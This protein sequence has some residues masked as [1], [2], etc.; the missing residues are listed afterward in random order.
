[1]L[2]KF[3][4][5][6]TQINSYSDDVRYPT[7]SQ[8]FSSNGEDESSVLFWDAYNQYQSDALLHLLIA[9][10]EDLPE[11]EQPC[12]R[13]DYTQ[14]VFDYRTELRQL[15]IQLRQADQVDSIMQAKN[16]VQTIPERDEERFQFFSPMATSP[17]P[18]RVHRPRQMTSRV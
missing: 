3:E 12:V 7:L 4:Y 14:L 15:A 18:L 10:C 13:P 9:P 2:I 5:A 1:M 8:A 16:W 6:L 11:I 17:H